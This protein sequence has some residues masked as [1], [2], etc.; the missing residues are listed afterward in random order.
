MSEPKRLIDAAWKLVVALLVCA[1]LL[2]FLRQRVVGEH[3]VAGSYP[4]IALQ[5]WF[6]ALLVRSCTVLF[7]LGLVVRLKRWFAARRAESA[8]KT[9]LASEH[10]LVGAPERVGGRRSTGSGGRSA[11][12]L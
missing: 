12:R 4:A 7:G 11:R 10:T 5:P 3:V 1:V 9:R 2:S 8:R 6:A